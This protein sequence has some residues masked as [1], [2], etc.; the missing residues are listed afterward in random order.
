MQ[1]RALRTKIRN[2]GRHLNKVEMV[3]QVALVNA[4]MPIV[5][6]DGIMNT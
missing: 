2:G 3:L 6:A 4:E 1:K 5:H